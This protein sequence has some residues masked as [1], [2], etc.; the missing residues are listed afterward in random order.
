MRG[1]IPYMGKI[2]Y[3]TMYRRRSGGAMHNHWIPSLARGKVR[4]TFE[5]RDPCLTNTIS[6]LTSAC[7]PPLLIE[8]VYLRKQRALS[9]L[10]CT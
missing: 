6:G 9:R 7:P 3:G 10:I 8:I 1:T 5:A 2:G 4:A